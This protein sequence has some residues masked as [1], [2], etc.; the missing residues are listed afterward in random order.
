MYASCHSMRLFS[1][2]PNIRLNTLTFKFYTTSGTHS[3][4]YGLLILLQLPLHS[5]FLILKGKKILILHSSF[6]IEIQLN[7]FTLVK[8]DK[9][10]NL[11]KKHFLINPN[12]L[13]CLLFIHTILDDQIFTN[14]W[15]INSRNCPI[16]N[17]KVINIPI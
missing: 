11:V 9:N 16:N 13:Y 1:L 15:H 7:K 8:V 12:I 3:F 14:V 4:V 10:T 6:F 17:T 2:L 5:F